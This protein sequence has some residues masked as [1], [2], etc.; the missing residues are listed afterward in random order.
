VAGLEMGSPVIAPCS[1]GIGSE[2]VGF[3]QA[4]RETASPALPP[5]R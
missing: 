2:R 5:Q 1:V 3:E 4:E